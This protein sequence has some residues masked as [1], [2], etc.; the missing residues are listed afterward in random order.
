MTFNSLP[1]DKLRS[2]FRAARRALSDSEQA[3]A[4]HALAAH[5]LSSAAYYHADKLAFF[6]ASDGELSVDLILEAAL[7][8][9]KQCFLPVA[10]ADDYSLRFLSY[11]GDASELTTNRWGILE[12]TDSTELPSAE[13]DLVFVPLVA[14]DQHGTR[15]GMGKGFYDRA[16]AFTLEVASSPA[17]HPL[18]VG[19]AHDCQVSDTAL[20]RQAWDV[21]L[22]AIATPSRLI[23]S[24]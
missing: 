14:C 19:V 2:H 6:L 8:A 12:P 16:F 10:D 22:S 24:F 4:A 20:P 23:A 21:P 3:E 18:L 13:L 1:T 5:F 9:G 7:A 11:H 17:T 15:L